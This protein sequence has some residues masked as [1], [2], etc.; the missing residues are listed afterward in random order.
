[1]KEKTEL[2]VLTSIQVLCNM[3]P[4]MN[5]GSF[6]QQVFLKNLPKYQELF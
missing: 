3:A 4:A 2:T 6:I 5:E 1:M